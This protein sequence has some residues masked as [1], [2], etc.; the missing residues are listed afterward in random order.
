VGALAWGA[1]IGLADR[2]LPALVLSVIAATAFACLGPNRRWALLA[3]APAAELAGVPWPI[4]AVGAWTLACW[5]AGGNQD[6]AQ[7]GDRRF[8]I[9]TA[10]LLTAASCA[11]AVPLASRQF[12][13]NPLIF[14]RPEPPWW[15]LPALVLGVAVANAV[16]EELLWRHGLQLV[17]RRAGV[18]VSVAVVLNGLSFGAAHLH[19]IPDGPLGAAAAA[20]FGGALASL[21]NRCGLGYAIAVHVAVDI[22]IFAVAAGH[23]LWFG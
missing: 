21:R 23:A 8:G 19:G 12:S 4:A 22:A 13:A 11:V 5:P 14:D 9:L 2:P 3:L 15:I 20:C 7:A 16:A 17:A 1:A 18:P 6:L 10:T